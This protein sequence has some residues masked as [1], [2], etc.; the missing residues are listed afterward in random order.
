MIHRIQD[1]WGRY[2]PLGHLPLCCE[3]VKGR[4][5]GYKAFSEK[6]SCEPRPN[7][8]VHYSVGDTF[9][10]EGC[11]EMCEW[12]LHFCPEV[13]AVFDYYPVTAETRV[14]EV[15]TDIDAETYR[16]G[17]KLVTNVLTIVRELSKEE[18]LRKV[19]DELKRYGETIGK[20]S[21]MFCDAPGYYSIFGGLTEVYRK[22][23]VKI[24]KEE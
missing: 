2:K 24:E 5:E 23:G 1:Y 12:G 11:I 21:M 7:I 13:T 14:C 18:I 6:L 19:R 16:H 15:V 8:I 22:I 3:R 17:N 20:P 4:V 9:V 10:Q